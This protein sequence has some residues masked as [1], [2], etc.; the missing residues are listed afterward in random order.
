MAYRPPSKWSSSKT[1]TDEDGWQT[2]SSNK[3]AAKTAPA[4]WGQS[5]LKKPEPKFEDE[6]PTISTR[7]APQ[8]TPVTS[9]QKT[10]TIAERMKQKLAEEEEQKRR[11]E[12]ERRRKAEEDEKNQYADEGL[13][14]H[15]ILRSRQLKLANDFKID[16]SYYPE[17]DGH[18][19]GEEDGYAPPHEYD[20]R[21]DSHYDSHYDNNYDNLDDY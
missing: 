10:L 11:E 18:Y 3:T 17:D 2:V 12:E 6:F 14:L 5:A 4:K 15:S 8:V 9:G 16:H 13:S 1:T 7:S 19:E 21:Y 20:D